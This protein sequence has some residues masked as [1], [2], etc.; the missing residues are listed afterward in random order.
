MRLVT[1]TTGGSWQEVRGLNTGYCGNSVTGL[2]CLRV[3]MRD[4]TPLFTLVDTRRDTESPGGDEVQAF[5]E[6]GR[7]TKHF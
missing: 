1:M 3:S 2:F 4:R 7:A 6:G 5:W